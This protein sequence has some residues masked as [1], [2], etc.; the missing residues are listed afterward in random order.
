MKGEKWRYA[1][2]VMPEKKSQTLYIEI[3]TQSKVPL[4]RSGVS[5]YAQSEETRLMMLSYAWGN[6]P[7]QQVD[8]YHGEPIPDDVI[9]G[10]LFPD[11]RKISSNAELVRVCLGKLLKLDLPAKQWYCMATWLSY[12]WIQQG[13][14]SASR[15]R[16]LK[17]GPT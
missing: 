14:F 9:E 2:I 5:R 3:I 16:N 11:V 8:A 15:R 1:T 4:S 7:V 13:L 17:E 12:I 10:L 6:G